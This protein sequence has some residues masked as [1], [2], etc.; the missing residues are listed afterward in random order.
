MDGSSALEL[1]AEQEPDPTHV[2]T[3]HITC[4]KKYGS[5]LRYKFKEAGRSGSYFGVEPALKVLETI[6]DA[7]TETDAPIG[8]VAKGFLH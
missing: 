1:V 5:G 6:M 8:L 4:S 2:T 3:G 7:R